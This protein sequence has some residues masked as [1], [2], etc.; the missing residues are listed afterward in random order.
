VGDLIKDKYFLNSMH[1][2]GLFLAILEK[3]LPLAI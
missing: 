3:R 2:T 1:A